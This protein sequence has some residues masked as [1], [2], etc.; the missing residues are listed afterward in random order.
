MQVCP[1]ASVCEIVCVCAS[2]R[3]SVR[4]HRQIMHVEILIF[5]VE[6][7][8]LSHAFFNYDGYDSFV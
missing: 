8:L 5:Y 3:M 4:E 2:A 1:G 6:A 7:K